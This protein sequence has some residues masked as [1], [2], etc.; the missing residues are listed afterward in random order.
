[1]L[2]HYEEADKS[3]TEPICET[4][5]E[6]PPLS[7]VLSRWSVRENETI[8][9]ERISLED[10]KGDLKLLNSVTA[11]E[12]DLA[13]RGEVTMMLQICYYTYLTLL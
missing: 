7:L 12:Y 10:L 1:M 2:K 5:P 11:T 8:T 3:R 9:R 13:S 6:T 4:E